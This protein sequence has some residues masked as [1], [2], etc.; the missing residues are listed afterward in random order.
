KNIA[1]NAKT[2]Q[3]GN[4]SASTKEDSTSKQHSMSQLAVDGEEGYLS[5]CTLVNNPGLQIWQLTFDKEYLVY[6]ILLYRRR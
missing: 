6:E 5:Q 1:L 4:D 3:T 2:S